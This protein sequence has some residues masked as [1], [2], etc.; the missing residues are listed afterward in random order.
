MYTASAQLLDLATQAGVGEK[1][2]PSIKNGSTMHNFASQAN[3][4]SKILLGQQLLQNSH[5]FSKDMLKQCQAD[6]PKLVE[7]S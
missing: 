1:L 6:D 3:G 5:L 4:I 7:N 2:H